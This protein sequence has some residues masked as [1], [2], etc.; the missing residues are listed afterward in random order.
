LV[1]GSAFDAF[2]I[3]SDTVVANLFRS[4][5]VDPRNEPILS[6]ANRYLYF[7][8]DKLIDPLILSP[9]KDYT[10]R[11]AVVDSAGSINLGVSDVSLTT[12]AVPEPSSFVMFAG[13]GVMGVSMLAGRKL[14]DNRR[15]RASLAAESQIGAPMPTANREQSRNG[16]SQSKF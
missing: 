10:L 5:L 12:T 7:S 2:S 1:A 11:F 4:D 3:A 16:S 6:T 13:L 14:R 15:K 9:G 8:L